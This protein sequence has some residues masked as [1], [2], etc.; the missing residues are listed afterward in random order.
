MPASGSNG[1]L[2]LPRVPSASDPRRPPPAG[3]FLLLDV[4][5]PGAIGGAS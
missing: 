3:G 5:L 2:P 4:P 1:A